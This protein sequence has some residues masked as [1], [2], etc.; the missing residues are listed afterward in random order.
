MFNPTD[1]T[2][3]NYLDTNSLPLRLLLG[4]PVYLELRLYCSKPE[5]VLLVNYCIAYP[6]SATNAL[7]LV[8]EG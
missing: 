6:R 3:S 1:Q 8:Y 5:A 7:V 4:A 2:Y